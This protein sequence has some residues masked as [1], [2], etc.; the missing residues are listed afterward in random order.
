MLTADGVRGFRSG[1]SHYYR[2]PAQCVERTVRFADACD[3]SEYTA[4]EGIIPVRS[5]KMPWRERMDVAFG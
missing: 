3:A 4:S 5:Q 2:C 1:I